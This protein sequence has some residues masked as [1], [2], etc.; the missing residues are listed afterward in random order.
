MNTK[1]DHLTWHQWDA[2][3]ALS[4]REMY[5]GHV[6]SADALT[7]YDVKCLDLLGLVVVVLA[8]DGRRAV[9]RLTAKGRAALAAH[10]GG[11]S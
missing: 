1:T 3:G 4:A 6:R 5:I 11:A 7:M 10:T 2:L 9:A 8:P